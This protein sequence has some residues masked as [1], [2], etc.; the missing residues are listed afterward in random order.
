MR[1]VLGNHKMSRPLPLTIRTLKVGTEAL[2]GFTPLHSPG[3]LS[4]TLLSQGCILV[5]APSV[6]MV[7]KMCIPREGVK[8]H[9]YGLGPIWGLMFGHII[10]MISFSSP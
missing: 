8:N 6:G 3:G 4:N 10:L 9:S 1:L 7:G 2:A 5:T